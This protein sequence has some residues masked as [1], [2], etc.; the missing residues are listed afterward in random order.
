[1][2]LLLY[3]MLSTE[4]DEALIDFIPSRYLVM[5]IIEALEGKGSQMPLVKDE[6]ELAEKLAALT[7]Q[8]KG[9]GAELPRRVHNLLSVSRVRANGIGGGS[10]AYLPRSTEINEQSLVDLQEVRDK[11]QQNNIIS[12]TRRGELNN[13]FFILCSLPFVSYRSCNSRL[14]SKDTED[15]EAHSSVYFQ[16]GSLTLFSYFDVLTVISFEE[17]AQVLNDK[18]QS[19]VESNQNSGVSIVQCV[20]ERYCIHKF[21]SYFGIEDRTAFSRL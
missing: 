2:V 18:S 21:D 3:C 6:A 19:F 13:I 7:M 16:V 11:V 12:I 20:M 17:I 1:M 15:A 5:R 14:S 8:L 10:A 4:V 9:S